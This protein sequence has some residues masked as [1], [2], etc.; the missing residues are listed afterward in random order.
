[1]GGRVVGGV[2]SKGRFKVEAPLPTDCIGKLSVG[3]LTAG[4]A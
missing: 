3:G 1:M 4:R 2:N